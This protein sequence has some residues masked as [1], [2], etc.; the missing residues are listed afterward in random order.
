MGQ[1][2]DGS[3]VEWVIRTRYTRAVMLKNLNI[4]IIGAGN[5][6]EA[7]VSGLLKKRVVQPSQI[8]ATDV[9]ESRLKHFKTQYGVRVGSDNAQAAKWCDILILAVK[10]QVIDEV[11]VGLKL[12]ARSNP[13]VLSVAAGVPIERIQSKLRSTKH[14]IRVMPNTPSIVLEGATA[15]AGGPGVSS[16]E[17]EIGKSIFEAVG[18]VVVVEET[19]IDTITGL[20]GGGPAYVY[21][22]IEALA[23][24]GVKMGLPREVAQLLAAQ[25]VLGAAKM[26]LESGE[27]PGA[28]KDR[29]ASPGGTTIAGLHSLEEGKLR[30]TVINAVQ[31]ATLR[32]RK[33][34][35]L[36]QSRH[37]ASRKN[38][39]GRAKR[40]T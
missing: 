15:L 14:I 5:I 38:G 22:F 4:A 33:L 6:A 25:T 32:S 16:Q 26:V 21:V 23:D 34:G 30:G 28:L 7:L 39:V 27:H 13:L 36:G 2:G 31:S 17:L 8:F 12:P 9:S 20:S 29:V 11:V 3:L 24:G 1:I 35:K 18:K 10:P 40:A 19:H 37:I